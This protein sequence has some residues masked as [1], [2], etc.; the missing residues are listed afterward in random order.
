MNG[1][2]GL[3]S[4][5]VTTPAFGDYTGFGS[6]GTRISQNSAP[7]TSM[8]GNYP[9]TGE[10]SD[11]RYYGMYIESSPWGSSYSRFGDVFNIFGMPRLDLG[12]IGSAMAAITGYIFGNPKL[13]ADYFNQTYF[14]GDMDPM[15]GLPNVGFYSNLYSQ[16]FAINAGGSF[17]NPPIYYNQGN[18]SFNVNSIQVVSDTC[19]NYN[20]VTGAPVKNLIII[21]DTGTPRAIPLYAVPR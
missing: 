4:P 8:G 20:T 21:D 13:Q 9:T 5:F 2:A 6:L 3:G 7:I 19:Y 17:S 12:D 15:S 18:L 11:L 14:L 10:A 16:Q 1:Y